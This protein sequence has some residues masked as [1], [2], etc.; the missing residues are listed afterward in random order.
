[1][2]PRE[3]DGSMK[4]RYVVPAVLAAGALVLSGCSNTDESDEYVP[5]D[6]SNVTVDEAAVA[7]LPDD[8]AE[9]GTLRVG[10]NPEYPPNEYKNA[11]GEIVGWGVDLAEAVAA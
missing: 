9:R 8:I 7:L 11:Q 2:T 5:Y 10:V 6:I 1:M 3:K 4:I